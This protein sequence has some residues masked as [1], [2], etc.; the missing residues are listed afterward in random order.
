MEDGRHPS[1]R[2]VEVDRRLSW[3]LSASLVAAR[4][5]LL[6][7]AHIGAAIFNASTLLLHRVE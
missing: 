1:N 5:N 3:S 6:A 7:H 2:R 4:T